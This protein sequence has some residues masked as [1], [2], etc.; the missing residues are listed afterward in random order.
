MP[1]HQKLIYRSYKGAMNGIVKNLLLD[2]E[3]YKTY[4][5]RNFHITGCNKIW[6]IDVSEFHI[7][8]D[9]FSYH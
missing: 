7:A 3:N 2:K 4:Y 6:A 1:K 8:A 5:E 9:S